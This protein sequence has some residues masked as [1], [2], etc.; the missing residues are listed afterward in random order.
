MPISAELRE[1]LDTQRAATQRL[2]EDK[3][4]EIAEVYADAAADARRALLSLD[5]ESATA[6]NYRTIVAIAEDTRATIQERLGE[7]LTST[8]TE[9]AV[10][11]RESLAGVVRVAAPNVLPTVRR[12]APVEDVAAVLDDMLALHY[13]TSVETYGLDALRRMRGAMGAAIAKGQTVIEA[14]QAIADA[15]GIEPWRAERI[16]RTEASYAV[17]RREWADV[18]AIA[19]D[20]PDEAWRKSLSAT[21][22]TRTGDDSR[23]LDGQAVPIDAPFTD[24][25]GDPY[26]HPPNRPNDRE[27]VIYLPADAM[28]DVLR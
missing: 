14:A 1:V 24:V 22:D 4:R 6:A 25:D 18:Q 12:I 27:V 2:A 7:T 17:N 21:F 28:Q 5:P 9:G 26:Q 13:Q 19:A 10:I 16:A 15:A 3:A 20:D 11:A 8:G 23:Q